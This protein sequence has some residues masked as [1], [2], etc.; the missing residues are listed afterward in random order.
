MSEQK[1]KTPELIGIPILAKIELVEGL[2]KWTWYEVVFFYDKWHSYESKTF[3]DG[4]N[5][6]EWKYCKECL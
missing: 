5:V 6:V 1:L 4:A 3:K 2:R